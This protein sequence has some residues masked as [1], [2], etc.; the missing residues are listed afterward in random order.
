MDDER[1]SEVD[2]PVGASPEPHYRLLQAR[3]VEHMKK[4][5]RA[6]REVFKADKATGWA[7]AAGKRVSNQM[8]AVS[9]RRYVYNKL[10]MYRHNVESRTSAEQHLLNNAYGLMENPPPPDP[11]GDENCFPPTV[12]AAMSILDVPELEICE[13][14][15][16]SMGFVHWWFHM[17]KLAQHY[18]TC[19]TQ[20]GCPECKCPHCGTCR[21]VK[22]K[23]GI[24]GAERCWFFFDCMHTKALDPDWASIVLNTQAVREVQNASMS[25]PSFTKYTEYKRVLRALP[26]GTK[27]QNVRLITS[28]SC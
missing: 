8:N 7:Q 5:S 1:R 28:P 12:A 23:K 22:D 16:C 13:V 24:H 17:P 6:A 3:L 14:H 19:S 18:R 10:S 25:K 9:V 4:N 20:G 27:P 21:F 26:A 11:A 15:M 2:V